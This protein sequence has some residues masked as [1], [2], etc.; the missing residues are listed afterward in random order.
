[1]KVILERADIISLLGKA[2]GK[3]LSEENVV[4]TPD[5]FEVIIHDASNILG[6]EETTVPTNKTETP[7]SSAVPRLGIMP[8]DEEDMESLAAA[9]RALL[10]SKP[11]KGVKAAHPQ[12]QRQLMAGESTEPRNPLEGDNDE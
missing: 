10:N 8:D 3:V 6:P 4:V 2:M 12:V 1:M 7:P 11:P 5:P 9:N